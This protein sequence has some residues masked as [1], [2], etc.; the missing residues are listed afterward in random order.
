MAV[1]IVG[2]KQL[3]LSSGPSGS[4]ALGSWPAG[5]AVS[6][7][8]V[9]LVVPD[10]NTWDPW[11]VP[12]GWS[13]ASRWLAWRLLS[14]ADVAGSVP[15]A[16]VVVAAGVVVFRGAS[17]VG[18]SSNRPGATVAAGGAV[19]SL[20]FGG[21]GAW[22]PKLVASVES[23]GTVVEQTPSQGVN[24]YGAFAE[25][26]AAGGWTE[27][28]TRA[29]GSEYVSLPLLPATVPAAP[30]LLAPAPGS[31]AA[32]GAVELSWLHRSQ[33]GGV[34]DSARVQVRL[35]G[36]AWQWVTAAGGLS[37]TV[38]TL[39]QSTPSKSVTLSAGSW[40]W[41][42]ETGEAGWWSPLSPIWALSVVARPVVPAATVVCPAG[43]LTPDVS[44][45]ATVGT[46]AVQV[47]QV[48][49]TA[50]PATDP[51]AALW[52]GTWNG[53]PAT[54]T[55][56]PLS[57]VNNGA[58]LKAWVR[59]A[60]TGGLWSAWRTSAWFTVSWTPPASPTLSVA[61]TAPVTLTVAAAGPG[62]QVQT[63]TG[64]GWVDIM[65]TTG[66]SVVWPRAPYGS[67]AA[68]RA[69][70]W[71]LADGVRLWSAWSGSVSATSTETRH[72][73]VGEDGTS[74]RRRLRGRS[75]LAQA[76]GVT[77]AYGLPPNLGEGRPFVDRT[78]PAGD[79]GSIT[80]S[81]DSQTDLLELLAWIDAHPVAW[82]CWPPT[83][84]SSGA[85][86]AVA[87][88]RVA[89]AGPPTRED[90]AQVIGRARVT[91]PWVQQ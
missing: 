29:T 81:C 2:Y 16:A 75:S 4:V 47:V 63:D 72:W 3:A 37:S 67:A 40:E 38:Q 62:V 78:P 17:G 66:S 12:A 91:I 53:S 27:I 15:A 71:T 48:A 8:A 77:V 41:A 52:S 42:V 10:S 13:S 65:E 83:G 22:K 26:N 82:I 87:P 39:A 25:V 46:G 6:D 54:V 55:T 14:A 64:S 56:G 19:V 20:G 61:G 85:R 49:I 60:Q 86:A 88:T 73:L 33:A 76:R 80:L 50:G 32:V 89:W 74:I 44:W 58:S 23:Q 24:T 35:N 51:S 45:T 36:G 9:M 1:S 68:Y 79:S 7:L 28:V 90:L 59:V 34:Q 31:Q 43:D 18:F 70:T 21:D 69:R 84:S 57:T 5:T 30:S 11:D